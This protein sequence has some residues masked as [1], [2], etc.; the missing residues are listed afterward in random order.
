MENLASAKDAVRVSVPLCRT[1]GRKI[2][3]GDLSA[4]ILGCHALPGRAADLHKTRVRRADEIQK[5]IDGNAERQ[6]VDTGTRAIAGDAQELG[7]S[8]VTC[9]KTREPFRALLH[10]PSDASESLDIVDSGRLVKVAAVGREGRPVAGCT[11][12]AFQRFDQGG[13]LTTDIGSGAELNAYVKIEAVF[14][15]DIGPKQVEAAPLLQYGLQGVPEVGVFAAQID[16][17]MAGAERVGGNRHSV[18]YDIGDFGQQYPVLESA[19][20]TLVGIADDMMSLADRLTAELPFE[21]GRKPGAAAAAKL[22]FCYL[23]NDAFR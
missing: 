5:L 12:L 22:G 17:S 11:A 18:E 14:P 6:L 19:G 8:R 13:F 15:A 16:Q 9:A 1:A 7:A 23:L 3:K 21:A 4:K 10:D 20:L 2:L